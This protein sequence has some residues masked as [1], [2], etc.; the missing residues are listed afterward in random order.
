MEQNI[1]HEMGTVVISG[2]VG[3]RL[4]IIQGNEK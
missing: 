3:V 1:G 2:F 4:G